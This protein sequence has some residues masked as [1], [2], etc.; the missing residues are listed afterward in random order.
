MLPVLGLSLAFS[1]P[2]DAYAVTKKAVP[3]FE[4]PQ[5]IADATVNLYCRLKA[6]KKTWSSSGTGVFIH[7]RGVILTNAHV[8][9][10]FLLAREEGR[11]TGWCSVRTSSPAK[12]RYT[13]AVLYIPPA[14]IKENVVEIG[15][16]TPKG[17]GENDFALLYVT[18]TEKAGETLPA[19]FPTLEYETATTVA[20][21]SDVTVAGYPTE[22]LSFSGVRNKLLRVA[23]TSTVESVRSF[24][25]SSPDVVQIAASRASAGGVSGGPVVSTSRDTLTAIVSTMSTAK[26]NRVLRAITL[27]YIDRAIRA[28]TG[29]SLSAI[30]AE[31]YPVRALI[32][33]SML[34]ADTVKTLSEALR[35]KK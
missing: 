28:Q 16:K 8:A 25:N 33:M 18:G 11:V 19:R 29:L 5:E 21:G 24:G 34:P 6:G 20:A 31:N 30:L 14:W 7:E 15:K 3:A 23:A 9:Q 35:K 12:E 27:T 13:A 32:T 22:K 1:F 2:A 17:T 26:D 4:A 10:Y